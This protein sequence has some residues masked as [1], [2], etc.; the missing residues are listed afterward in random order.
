MP[1]SLLELAQRA[2]QATPNSSAAWRNLGLIL[3]Q[4]G[5]YLEAFDA[6]GRALGLDPNDHQVA[7]ALSFCATRLGMKD[8]ALSLASYYVQA[9]PND[10]VGLVTLANALLGLDRLA[11]AHDLAISLLT[12][13]PHD[14][15]LWQLA[16]KTARACGA[17]D[18]AAKALDQANCLEPNNPRILYDL[19]WTLADLAE[20]ETALDRVEQAISLN[21]DPDVSA[22]LTFLK[23]T[24]LL[25]KGD[26]TGGWQAYG[27]RHDLALA[28]AAIYDLELARW[29]GQ[30]SLEGKHVL[31]MA[32][33]GLGDELAHMGLITDLLGHLG[34]K[35]RVTF[36]ADK[37]LKGLAERSWPGVRAIGHTTHQILGR[38]HRMPDEKV[39]ADVW[40]PIG[41][42]LAS[43]RP[44]LAHF[45][46]PGGYLKPSP[47]RLAHWRGWLQSLK[48]QV[49][50][51]MAWRSHKMD[52]ERGRNFAPLSAWGPILSRP[53][54]SFINLQYGHT[55][56]E[57]AALLSQFGVVVHQPPDLDLFNDLEGLAA[58]SAALDL[59]IGC[60]NAST[61][62]LGAVGTPL[63]IIA[64]PAPW[65]ALGQEAYPWYPGARIHAPRV[66]G[67]WAT[68]VKAA[69]QA[70]GA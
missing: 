20:T 7:L 41:D 31:L 3:Q 26:L 40:L 12:A 67:D 45:A 35:G 49:K 10:Q 1:P 24:L 30:A 48:G 21:P 58:L 47:G 22:A 62:L 29:D 46:Q 60:S 5:A 18:E 4:D 6:Y 27:I 61:N 25:A 37:R 43:L 11:E 53:G 68:A 44:S 54:A 33:Q 39:E 56:A 64:P 14:P 2:T 34:P 52:D 32:E 8:E 23:A 57:R 13:A 36:C 51:G 66:Y 69:A 70:I 19:A 17:L 55:D 50:I 63:H 65:P 16:G 28:S 15:S 9:R 38:R 59:C 42:L